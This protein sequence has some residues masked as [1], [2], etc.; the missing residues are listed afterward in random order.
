MER[1]C[2]K[3]ERI[4]AR[5]EVRAAQRCPLAVVRD[6]VRLEPDTTM[7]GGTWSEHVDVDSVLEACAAYAAAVSMERDRLRQAGTRVV[8]RVVT[9]PSTVALRNL[10]EASCKWEPFAVENTYT[11]VHLRPGPDG[12]LVM[13]EQKA[14]SL[15]CPPVVKVPSCPPSD[16]VASWYRTGFWTLLSVILLVLFAF[17]FRKLPRGIG[18]VLL[19]VAT[20]L[21]AQDWTRTMVERK[22]GERKLVLTGILTGADTAYLQVYHDGDELLDEVVAGTW[23][24]ELGAYTT[25]EL[26]FTDMLGRVKRLSVHELSDDMVEF[27]PPLEVDFDRQGNLVL[28][29]PSN[30]KP[31]WLEYDV[32]LSRKRH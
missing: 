29:K 6:S 21:C 24:L 2:R 25:Y 12:P 31:D 13:L 17:A 5:A 27:Y 28:L 23:H 7:G 32:G 4:M 18:V 11:R 20:P 3:A 14:V 9:R 15:P 8:E 10:Q 1:D 26:K 19:L 22:P 16:G 30:G